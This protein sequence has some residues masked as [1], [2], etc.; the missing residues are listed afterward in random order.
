MKFE[1]LTLVENN[2]LQHAR[3]G[4]VFR[5]FAFLE[6]LKTETDTRARQAYAQPETTPVRG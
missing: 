1:N 6:G 3:L 4:F 5:R 2:S